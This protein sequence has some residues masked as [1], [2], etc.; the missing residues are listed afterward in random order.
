MTLTKK[1]IAEVKANVARELADWERENIPDINAAFAWMSKFPDADK[2]FEE[3]R[4]SLRN[5]PPAQKRLL[6]RSRCR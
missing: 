5:I 1:Q 2:D 6:R 4:E 3:L